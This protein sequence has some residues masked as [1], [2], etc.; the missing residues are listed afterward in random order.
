VR[1]VGFALVVASAVAIG[2]GVGV[3]TNAEGQDPLPRFRSDLSDFTPQT[4]RDFAGF[5]L[6]SLGTQF[7][8]LPLTAIVRIDQESRLKARGGFGIPDNRPNHMNFIYGTCDATGHEGGCAPPLTVQIW[9]ACD[10]T[11]Q[12]YYYNVRGGGP[13]RPYQ[14]VTVRGVPAAS[15][16]DMLEIYSGR[17]TIVIFGGTGALRA[18]AAASLTS[19]NTL[20]GNASAGDPLPPPVPGAMEGKLKC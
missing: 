7:E 5:P 16:S 8:E 14:R 4:V 11:L 17:V 3:A 10:R 1:L 20:A 9:P 19:A 15:F 18:R 13:S 2:V 12:D 6:Y